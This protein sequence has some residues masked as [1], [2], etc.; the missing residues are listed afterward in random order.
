MLELVRMIASSG[1]GFVCGGLLSK[2]MY[3]QCEVR[4]PFRL[5]TKRSGRQRGRRLSTVRVWWGA[6]RVGPWLRMPACRQSWR[7][8]RKGGVFQIAVNSQY[9]NLSVKSGPEDILRRIARAIALRR[10]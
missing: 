7:Q 5:L 10:A 2:C 4:L 1:T 3:I 6:A 8:V 9:S